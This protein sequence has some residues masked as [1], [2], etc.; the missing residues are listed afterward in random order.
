[1]LVAL[2]ACAESAVD[3]PLS[4]LPESPVTP[5]VERTARAV[6]ANDSLLMAPLGAEVLAS[7]AAGLPA[8]DDGLIGRNREWGRMY[9]SRFQMGTGT[10]LRM[11]LI[12]GRVTDGTRAVRGIEVAFS[13]MQQDGA[14]PASVPLSVSMGMQPSD[15]DVASGAAFFLGDACLGLLALEA[16]AQRD[17]VV[18]ASQRASLRASAQ[19]AVVWLAGKRALLAAADANAPNRLLFDARAYHACGA[20][21]DDTVT[22]QY[23]QPFIEAALGKQ[24]AAGW[25]A[26]GDGWDTSYQA[27]ALD[28]GMDVASVLNSGTARAALLAAMHRGA[29]WLAQRVAP[30][31][32]VNSVGNTRT[33]SG[34]ESFLGDQKRLALTSVV[35]GLG[36]VATGGLNEPT[37]LQALPAAR[38]VAAWG[39]G[40]PGV[41]P[42]FEL[43]G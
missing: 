24:N 40:N 25:F 4:P 36:K 27:V 15:A 38:R 42:C 10:A 31:G 6:R 28:I 19:Q 43:S 41:D 7:V 35:L 2:A 26:E 5:A 16:H 29:A 20:L 18:A 13:T 17:A 12:A 37:T 1:M 11:A 39:L 3:T 14:L 34:G 22:Q 33:C 23:A 30:D 21:A 32:R 9:A 8:A